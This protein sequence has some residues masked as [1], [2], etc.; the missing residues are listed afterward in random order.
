L[1]V[2]SI[3]NS[4][5]AIDG[6]AFIIEYTF[7][8]DKEKVVGQTKDVGFQIGVRKTFDVS[9]E[10][11]WN[12]L[13]SQSGLITW[14]GEIISGS[15]ELNKPFKT[16][17]GVEGKITTLNSKSN[18]RLSW[19]P[20]YWTNIS[21][22]QIRVI[23]SKDKATVSFHQDKLLDSKQREEMKRYW[24]GVLLKIGNSLKN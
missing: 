20:Q 4:L 6:V 5:I 11:A 10:T 23:S 2:F 12:F 19:K 22:L 7:F 3:I 9:I 14:L 16:K 13:F 21:S 24:D 17:E 15:F 8:M 1:L 18:I